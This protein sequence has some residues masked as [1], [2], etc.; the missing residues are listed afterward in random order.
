MKL[1]S[2]A[3]YR[4]Y[5][6]SRLGKIDLPDLIRLGL[7]QDGRSMARLEADCGFS[8]PRLAAIN[9]PNNPKYSPG[10]RTLLIALM[11]L[12]YEIRIEK[13]SKRPSMLK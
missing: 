1:Q 11:E 6:E 13:R 7:K 4:F 10:I 3:D 2:D 12:G 8:H 9:Y 5:V